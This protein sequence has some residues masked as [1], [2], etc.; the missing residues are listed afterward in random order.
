MS[1]NLRIFL[2]GATGVIGRRLI[3]LLIGAGH[4]VTAIGRTPGKCS[5]LTKQGA[6]PVQVDL[7]NPNAVR[8]A[9]A[10]HDVVINLVTHIPS[11]TMKM[12]LPGAWQ[13]ND[14][15]R[16]D[17]SAILAEAAISEGVKRFIQES[18]AP[19]YIDSGDKWISEDSPVNPVRY[20]RT[21][22][23]A[24]HSVIRFTENKG[25]GVILRFAFFYGPDAYQTI[26]LIKM[27][28]KGWA[29]IPGSPDAFFSSI[30]H[31][32]AATAVISA[33]QL[34]AGIYNVVDNE[35]VT[36]QEY[37]NSLAAYLNVK[38]PKFPPKWLGYFSGS[39]GKL[40]ARS[41]R[42]SNQKLRTESNWTPKYPGIREGW[43]AVLK[44]KE[45]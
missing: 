23:D 43:H 40:M 7:F 9:I 16:R 8:R 37:V 14:R 5:T 25:T 30:S 20:N 39:L 18:F 15:L 10:G 29:P 33:L 2:T 36:R 6:E 11:S 38:T 12:F 34:N 1:N 24:E 45:I 44:E 19:I 17:A 27:V 35:P 21:V 3:P 31:D 28:R 42:I 22:L 32:D 13:E 26:D 41:L 4:R